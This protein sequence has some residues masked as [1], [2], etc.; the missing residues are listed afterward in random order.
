M[1]VLR[2]ERITHAYGKKV[3]LQ[4][5][6]TTI[7]NGVVALLG[8][9]GAGKSTLIRII[10]GHLRP[11][12][13]QVYFEG[14][15]LRE[16]GN[17]Y[18]KKIGY[19]PQHLNFYKNFT[20]RQ[21]LDYLADLKGLSRKEAGP[22]IV[23]LLELVN[24]SEA[25]QQRVGTFSGG[26]KQRLGIAQALLNNPQLLILDEPTAGLDPNERIR[27]RNTLAK[28]SASRIVLLATHI[29]SDVECIAK[30]V[31]LL[32]NG[33]LLMNR[34]PLE[35]LK[36]MD[37]KVWSLT[38]HSEDQ[39]NDCLRRYPVSNIQESGERQYTLKLIGPQPPVS[40]AVPCAPSL[41]DVFLFYFPDNSGGDRS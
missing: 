39:V 13:G 3:A 11:T 40:G 31:L 33:C 36:E 6:D 2:L 28:I 18:Y 8:P 24:L 32:K 25:G 4:E 41:E 38:V 12:R 21:F 27:F 15:N 34:R 5:V 10:I 22:R 9:N 37:G 30:R 1:A 23:E 35:L 17:A 14:R 19:V 29:V 16:W 26:M 20:A 7:N